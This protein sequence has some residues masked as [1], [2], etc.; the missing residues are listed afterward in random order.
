[1]RRPKAFEWAWRQLLPHLTSE[2]FEACRRERAFQR[3]KHRMWKDGF[4][5]P[6]QLA[7]G[8]SECFCGAPIDT[9]NTARHIYEA[10]MD[11]AKQ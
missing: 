4:K 2:S 3:W 1:M 9:G 6:T 10:H 5:L 11:S 7:S 8:R